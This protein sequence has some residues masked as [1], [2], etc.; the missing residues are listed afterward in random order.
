MKDL[1]HFKSIVWMMIDI[2]FD[3]MLKLGVV[4]FPGMEGLNLFP[5]LIG[6]PFGI[7]L[8]KAIFSIFRK[9]QKNANIFV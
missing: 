1:N 5:L 2:A 6:F 3:K 8:F 7:G 9:S 4:F